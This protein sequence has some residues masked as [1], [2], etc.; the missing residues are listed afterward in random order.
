MTQKRSALTQI[1]IALFFALAMIITS[2]FDFYEGDKMT[3]IYML[4]AAWFVVS[5][6]FNCK[7]T[8]EDNC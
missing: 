1:G 5:N 3:T 8:K 2:Y 7:V 4:I 6:R